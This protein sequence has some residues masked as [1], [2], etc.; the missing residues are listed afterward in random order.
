MSK[1]FWFKVFI[2]AKVH[3]LV[4]SKNSSISNN[5]VLHKYAV[6]ISKTV[7][8]LTIQFFI[9]TQFSSIWPIDRTL[10]GATTP[11]QTGPGAMAMKGTPYSPKLQ[12]CWNFT[13][14]LFSVISTTLVVVVVGGGGRVLSLCRDAVGVFYSSIRLG[15][16]TV[17]PNDILLIK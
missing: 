5:S 13:I 1:Q 14:R 3:D 17:D 15:N 6:S 10:S 11:G 4:I 9:S 16:L 7:L 8:F 12:Y 2:L